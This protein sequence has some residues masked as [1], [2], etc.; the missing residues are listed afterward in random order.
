[1]QLQEKTKQPKKYYVL[2]LTPEELNLLGAVC[3]SIGGNESN[4]IRT[5]TNEI[6][7]EVKKHLGDCNLS[8]AFNK[9][10]QVMSVG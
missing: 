4:S 2:R 8:A 7:D 9:I 6:Y 10:T 3:G 5:L 1:M